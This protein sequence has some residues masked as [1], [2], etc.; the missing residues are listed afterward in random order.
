ML[1][2]QLLSHRGLTA[3]D[4]SGVCLCCVVPAVLYTVQKAIRRYLGQEALTVGSGVRTGM[5]VRVDNPREVGA[6]RIVVHAEAPGRALGVGIP[7]DEFELEKGSPG[8]TCMLPLART[9]PLAGQ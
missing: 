7:D 9:L 2:L 1:L 6:D 4:I 3:A 5:R 8:S